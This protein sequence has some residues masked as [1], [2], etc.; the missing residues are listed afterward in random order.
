MGRPYK[1]ALELVKNKA[2]VN[3]IHKDNNNTNNNYVA[4]NLQKV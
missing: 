3:E 4:V 1:K 2:L